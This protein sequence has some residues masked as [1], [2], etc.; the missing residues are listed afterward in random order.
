MRT[1][2]I[3][4]GAGIV[5][6]LAA[7]STPSI[8]GGPQRGS[9]GGAHGPANPPSSSPASEE[10]VTSPPGEPSTGTDHA[11]LMIGR[12]ET[13][14][15]A[16]P[17]ASWPGTRIIAR[18]EGTAV[19]V[20]LR[21]FAEPWMDGAPS[22]WEVS[23]DHGEWRP[24][25]MIPDDQPHVF[26]LA[27]GLPP[28]PHEVE[29]YK[30]SETQ[31]G[32]TQFLG[33]D[34][35]GGKSLPSP[36]HKQRKIEVM[37][38]SQASGFGIEM[39]DAP[40]LDCPGADHAGRYQNFRKAW[41]ALL[42]EMFD[43]EVHAI[44]YSAKGLIKNL[45]PTDYDALVDYYPRA[46]PNPAAAHGMQ[47]F[48]LQSW[49]PDVIVLTQGSCDFVSGV[50][51]DAFRTAY[52]DFVVNTLRA[53]APNAHI[54]MS[55]LGMGGRGD[56]DPI[57]REIIEERAAVGDDKMHVVVAKPYTWEE[58]TACNAHGSPAW[59]RRIADEL[60]A[61]IKKALGW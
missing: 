4:S 27:R 6:A 55:V 26:E 7:C 50:D 10:P 39:L 25:E 18:F 8:R 52:R 9:D 40:E 13:T 49:I 42:G 60:G 46:N 24:I 34:F 38:D 41:G 37:G 14:D 56:I 43:A 31:T 61:E 54:F 57:A 45:W 33:F 16:G 58:M 1:L 20:R 22:F 19:S 47:L 5:I 17:K 21:E 3:H 59:H 2:L 12:F 11:P 15:P 44:V 30:R 35:H 29:L 53:R 48:D 36:E 28:G 32:I 23:I 51:F